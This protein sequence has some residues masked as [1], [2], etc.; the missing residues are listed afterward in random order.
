MVRETVYFYFHE[1][2]FAGYREGYRNISNAGEYL[3]P[4]SKYD[5]ELVASFLTHH[6]DLIDYKFGNKIHLPF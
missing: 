4:K 3:L 5:F 1:V 2:L 6:R